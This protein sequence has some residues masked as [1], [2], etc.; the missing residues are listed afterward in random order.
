M[1]NTHVDGGVFP[2]GVPTG[3]IM[4][5]TIAT[6]LDEED[7]SRARDADPVPATADVLARKGAKFAIRRGHQLA[8]EV[9]QERCVYFVVSGALYLQS[10]IADGRRLIVNTYYRGDFVAPDASAHLPQERLVVMKG[11]EV[12]RVK[13][14]AFD[15]SVDNLPDL[16]KYYRQM[17]QLRALREEVHAV[18][19]GRL[20]GDER[21]ASYLIEAGRVFGADVKGAVDIELPMLRSEMADYL[22]LNSDTLSRLVTRLKS[23]RIVTFI[24]RH[25]AIVEN[26]ESLLARSPIAD[27]LLQ[28]YPQ[29]GRPG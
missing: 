20:T 29:S 7:R 12:V 6:S 3:A 9:D 26:W 28:A 23:E 11:G 10:E 22:A 2:G 5:G 8:L 15:A 24:G 27:I 4:A 25:R 19:L 1:L 14:R 21:M 17:L 13:R 16:S 18:I